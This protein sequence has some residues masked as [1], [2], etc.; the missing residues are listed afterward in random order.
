MITGTIYSMEEACAAAGIKYYQ[1]QYWKRKGML[2][3]PTAWGGRTVYS[4]DQVNE[5]KA[6]FAGRKKYQGSGRYPA[7][8]TAE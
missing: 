2:P 8:S 3:Q 6:F 7:K 1:L 5:V 4:Q